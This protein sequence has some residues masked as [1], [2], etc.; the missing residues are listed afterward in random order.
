MT[1]TSVNVQPCKVQ[2]AE[3]HNGRH[4]ELSYLIP[5]PNR[6]NESWIS[7][8]LRTY[9]T[10]VRYHAALAKMVKEKT[11]RTMQA[12]ATPIR[13]AVVVIKEDTTMAELRQLAAKFEETWGIKCLRIDTHFDEGYPRKVEAGKRNLHA[14]MIFD[15]Q[16]WES[17]KSIKLANIP[18]VDEKG[19]PIL[20]EKGKQVTVK[21]TTLMQD[22]AAACLNMDR[23][24]SSDRKH[25]SA[26][27]YKIEAEK[28]QLQ[29]VTEDRLE[30]ETKVDEAKSAIERLEADKTKVTAELA[31]LEKE[32]GQRAEQLEEQVAALSKTK[33]AKEATIDTIKAVGKH[34]IDWATGKTKAREKAA[35]EQIEYLTGQVITAREI[36]QQEGKKSTLQAILSAARFKLEDLTPEN[37]GKRW[38]MWFD[39]AKSLE[40][41]VKQ[42]KE[43]TEMRKEQVEELRSNIKALVEQYANGDR[44]IY[45]KYAIPSLC[46][47][48]D[49]NRWS[50]IDSQPSRQ[51]EPLFYSPEELKKHTN[52]EQAKQQAEAESVPKEE[53]QEQETR[54]GM[55]R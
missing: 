22:M 20:D 5:N 14:H 15:Y 45:N 41:D 27:A 55:R 30:Y 31:D 52:Q 26:L 32:K 8:R 4:K 39:K 16:D 10:L 51:T 2:S 24:E 13:E 33:A 38:R 7:D 6:A 43:E 54:R 37:I 35:G 19:K 44:R 50:A 17:G 42:L 11:G 47:L 29:Q 23:G 9:G 3:R 48:E 25:L 36:G 40:Q 49:S 21:P 46:S 28:Q 18:A 1:K 12:K 34:A 53:K